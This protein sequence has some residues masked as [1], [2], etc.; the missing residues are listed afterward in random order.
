MLTQE[1]RDAIDMA[2]RA[3]SQGLVLFNEP[4]S[5]L[6]TACE[7][8]EEENA[9]LKGELAIANEQFTRVLA[10]ASNISEEHIEE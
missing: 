9:K 5:I 7:R 8:I 3:R 2:R 1:E 10:A 4:L 6:A